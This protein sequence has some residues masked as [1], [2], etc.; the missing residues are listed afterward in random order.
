M[1]TIEEWLKAAEEGKLAS[2]GSPASSVPNDSKGC[3]V[4]QYI[5]KHGV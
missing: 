2:W 4:D 5:N 3:T 1:A